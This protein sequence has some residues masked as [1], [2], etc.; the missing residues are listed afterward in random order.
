MKQMG[1]KGLTPMFHLLYNS[2]IVEGGISVES[3]ISVLTEVG[4]PI[5]VTFYLLHRVEGKLD[6]LI[7]AIQGL[8]E[9]LK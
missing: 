5:L 2:N 1:Y 3:W 7:D 8:P 6:V 4:F 9:K